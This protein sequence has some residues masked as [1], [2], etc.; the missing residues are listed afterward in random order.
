MTTDCQ[1]CWRITEIHYLIFMALQTTEYL[2]NTTYTFK[3]L[4]TPL[5]KMDAIVLTQTIK[6]TE[7]N[8]SPHS[9]VALVCMP[10]LHGQWQPHTARPGPS[11]CQSGPL[12]VCSRENRVSSS[13]SVSSFCHHDPS[14]WAGKHSLFPFQPTVRG[15]LMT[16]LLAVW[17]SSSGRLS[18]PREFFS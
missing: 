7:H 9:S 11:A 5:C 8:Q 12:Q 14:E 18:E 4:H 3:S 6:G 2:S 17:L 15:K 1:W 13:A 10:G 16:F